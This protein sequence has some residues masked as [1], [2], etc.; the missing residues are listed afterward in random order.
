VGVCA[1]GE[2]VQPGEATKEVK[3][4]VGNES[5]GAARVFRTDVQVLGKKGSVDA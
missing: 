1:K 2:Q 4:V 3:K 5:G